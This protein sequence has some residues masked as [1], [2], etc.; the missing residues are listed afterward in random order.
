MT[1]TQ[2]R[3]RKQISKAARY[4]AR[5]NHCTCRNL[6]FPNSALKHDAV[7][8]ALKPNQSL[9]PF[10]ATELEDPQAFTYSMYSLP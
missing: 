7:I 6:L 4:K 10:N 9:D 2:F 1:I 8:I 3:L 5:G